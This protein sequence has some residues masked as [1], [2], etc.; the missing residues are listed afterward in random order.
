MADDD[1]NGAATLKRL[2]APR[3]IALFG[4][5]WADA[6][7]AAAQAIGYTG[8]VWRVH[9]NRPSSAQSRYFRSVDE[10]PEA[11]DAAF[12]AAPNREVPAIAA[13]LAR[14]GA[15]GFVCFAAGFSETGTAEGQRLA[16]ALESAA[17]ALPYFGPNCYGFINLFDGAA[18][19]PDQ[20]VG[21]PPARGVA[22]I[23]Q[24]G[25][26]ALNLLFNQR[27]LPIGYLITTGNQSRLA[28]EDL[29][30]RL[31]DDPRVSAFGL[32][33]EGIKDT[34][35]FARAAARARAA[36]KP[37]ALIKTGRTAAA[38]RTVHSHTG[39]LAGAD[40]S[41]DAFCRQAGIARC[42][43]LAT[44]CETLKVLHTGGPLSGRRML[45][46][47]ASG[48]DMAMT[49]DAARQL[50]VEFPPFSSET[51]ARLG[52]LLSDRVTIANPFDFHT[53]VW[54]DVPRLQSL[55]SIVHG[56]GYDSVG[57]TV[58]CPP[59]DEA[60]PASYV[61]VIEEFIAAYP[62]PPARAAIIS[63]LPESLSAGTRARCL[64]AGVTPLQGQREALE[65]LDHAAA[66]GAAWGR[67]GTVEIRQ[68]RAGRTGGRTLPEHEGKAALAAYGVPIPRSRVVAAD[69]AAAAAGAIGFPVV[70]KAT[71]AVE[72]K[73]D[74]GG[75]ILNVRTA[76]DATAAAARLSRI[77]STL[78]VEEMVSEAVAE[79][80]IGITVDPQFGALLVMGAGGV[81]A[82]LLQDTATLLPPFTAVSVQAAL[83]RLGIARLLAGYRGRPPGDLP[84]LV[85]AVLACARYA[86][87]NV[88]R[89]LELDLNPVIVRPAGL[90][91]VAVDALVRLAEET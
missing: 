28:V 43:S 65:A 62:G 44:L 30:D 85:S 13:A 18:L 16:A 59:E 19:W 84:A 70:M 14:R 51:S 66:I 74:I 80:L 3:H 9:P 90:G 81:L 69:E 6:A 61:A 52:D 31:V 7:A 91:V 42:D 37:I 71:G 77:S 34:A 50:T 54:F 15:G 67:G 58:D 55:F 40:G 23:C 22:L 26:I 68:P 63:S 86:E 17:G 73:S 12:I 53:H 33:I 4:G 83:G 88:D 41:F 48:G 82:E 56:A 21:A 1:P 76:A 87:D 72:H 89:L 57:L 11:P 25:T 24:S 8:E 60:D 35:S 10:L 79:V 49:A 20:L 5:Q 32:Y 38:A 75:V 2:L 46:M 29:I 47:G 64:A 36:G 39:S 45:I 27:S 78:L